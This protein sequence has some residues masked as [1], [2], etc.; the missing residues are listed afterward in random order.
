MRIGIVL[1]LAALLLSAPATAAPAPA[2]SSDNAYWLV[3]AWLC[4]SSRPNIT[5]LT[6]FTRNGDGS[7]ALKTRNAAAAG[8]GREF[9]DAFRFDAGKNRWQWSSKQ[10]DDPGFLENGTAGPWMSGAWEFQGDLFAIVM[11]AGRDPKP[12][13]FH[14]ALRMLFIRLND[15]TYERDFEEYENGIWARFSSSNCART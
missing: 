8:R 5:V 1:A 10:V 14:R 11:K 15:T 12:L 7:L 6:T 9:D 13:R 3:G 4:R 2:P